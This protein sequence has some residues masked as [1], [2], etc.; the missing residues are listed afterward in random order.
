MKKQSKKNHDSFWQ[1]QMKKKRMETLNQKGV[2]N[3]LTNL[4]IKELW[5]ELMKQKFCDATKI[6]Y[7]G[8][9]ERIS[10]QSI[11]GASFDVTHALP[12]KEGGFMTLRHNEVRDKSSELLNEVTSQCEKGTNSSGSQ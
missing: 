9:L 8:P 1:H 6:R 12:C 5:Y 10:S 3:W 4:P 2:L 11:C 7:K